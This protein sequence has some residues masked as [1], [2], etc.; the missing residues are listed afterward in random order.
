MSVQQPL[1]GYSAAGGG[2]P[3]AGSFT[4]VV[5]GTSSTGPLGRGSGDGY[6]DGTTNGGFGT[7]SVDPD[8]ARIG[9]AGNI[10]AALASNGAVNVAPFDATSPSYFFIVDGVFVQTDLNSLSFTDNDGLHTFT[11]AGAAA[12]NANGV[13]AGKSIWQFPTADASALFGVSNMVVTTT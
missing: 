10:V 7:G 3:L 5:G 6:Q 9:G 13:L 12:F 4:M 11:G 1:L 2:G 8:P